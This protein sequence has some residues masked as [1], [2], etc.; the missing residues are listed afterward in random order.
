DA[1][2]FKDRVTIVTPT[3]R[4]NA[5][6]VRRISDFWQYLGARVRLMSPEEHDRALAMTSHLPHLLASA[7]AAALPSELQELT[8]TGFRD[9]TR[10]AAGDPAI[11]TGIFAQNREAVLSAL[12]KLQG[13]LQRFRNAMT[14][15]DTSLINDLLIQA[16]RVRDAL[17]S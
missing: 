12:E 4:T 13:Q 6:A 11:W 5:F 1:D 7:L 3:A 10:V 16:K 8:G 17:G 15:K 2:L 9:C 14:A